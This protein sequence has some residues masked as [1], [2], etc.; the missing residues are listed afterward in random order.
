M[1]LQYLLTL[2]DTEGGTAMLSHVKQGVQALLKLCD[3]AVQDSDRYTQVCNCAKCCC[4]THPCVST[5]VLHCNI[6][7]QNPGCNKSLAGCGDQAANH[8]LR[9]AVGLASKHS[10]AQHST[11]QHS[12]AQHST[13]QHSTAQHSTAQHDTARHS[14]TQHSTA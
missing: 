13:A 11:A 3:Q 12:T 9:Q 14:T 6:L 2:D 7:L 8:K 5:F 10:T 1:M 4:G